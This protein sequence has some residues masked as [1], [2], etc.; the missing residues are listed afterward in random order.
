MV[1]LKQIAIAATCWSANRID[2][3]RVG[4]NSDLQRNIFIPFPIVRSWPLIL[5]QHQ[6]LFSICTN[7]NSLTDLWYNGAFSG[8]E[9]LGGILTSV[10]TITSWEPN[11]LDIVATGTDWAAW[12]KWWD[13]A[14]W[15][16][17]ESQGGIFTSELEITS[18]APGRLDFFGR[19]TDNALYHKWWN[20]NSWGGYES[21]GG[22]LVGPVTAVDWGFN[23][24]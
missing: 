6:H 1:N 16:G 14:S 13:G 5:Q 17:W 9:S 15:S 20:G 19:G 21:L 2:I 18:W 11:R 23:R 22:I 8:W 10:P 3:F 4:F 12:H 7:A 24:M